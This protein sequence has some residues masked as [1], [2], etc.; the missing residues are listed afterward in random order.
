LEIKIKRNVREIHIFP[1]NPIPPSIHFL[2]LSFI[3]IWVLWGSEDLRGGPSHSKTEY[4][5]KHTS[6]I[7]PSIDFLF[8]PSSLFGCFG[9]D[10]VE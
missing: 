4:S 7:Q 6:P 1:N 10:E 5:T 2:F 8:F 9:E 3:F